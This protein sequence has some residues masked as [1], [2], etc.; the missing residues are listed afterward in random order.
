MTQPP[1]QPWLGL[2]FESLSLGAEKKEETSKIH[3]DI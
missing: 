2:F 3:V 1:K